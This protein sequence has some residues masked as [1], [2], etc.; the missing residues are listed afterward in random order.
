MGQGQDRLLILLVQS[1][2]KTQLADERGE[3]AVCVGHVKT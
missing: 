3:R 2:V 1:G